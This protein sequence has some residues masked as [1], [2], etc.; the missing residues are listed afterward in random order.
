MCR[1]PSFRSVGVGPGLSYVLGLGPGPGLGSSFTLL[2]LESRKEVRS[3]LYI[4]ASGSQAQN[5]AFIGVGPDPFQKI[6]PRFHSSFSFG[7]RKCRVQVQAQVLVPVRGPNFWVWVPIYVGVLG[8]ASGSKFVFCSGYGLESQSAVQVSFVWVLTLV[9][10]PKF[11]FQSQSQVLRSQVQPDF[12]IRS[13]SLGLG[14][15]PAN[16]LDPG[17][18]PKRGVIPISGSRSCL[19]AGQRSQQRHMK[20]FRSRFGLCPRLGLM[21]LGSI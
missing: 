8:P 11:R 19:D 10:S 5:S 7:S 21:L 2:V 1:G 15:G 3:T 4:P 9:W 16:F 12:G 6:S 14:L 18:S 20:V 17:S 13:E